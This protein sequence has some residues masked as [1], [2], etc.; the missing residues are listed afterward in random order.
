M[1]DDT[2][3]VTLMWANNEI[4]TINEVPQIGALC[5]DR[6]V[7]LPHRRDAVGRQD[8]H[9]CQHRQHRPAELSAVTRST[10]P[11]ASARSTSGAASPAS[12]SS[13]AGRR[14]PR[15]RHALAARSTSPAS[16]G[17]GKACEIL[18]QEMD[19]ERRASAGCAKKLERA[20][21]PS[22]ITSGQRR[23]RARLPHLDQHLLRLRRGR[24]AD[25]GHQG[26]R[27]ELGLGLHLRQPRAQLC[28]Q[29]LSASAMTGPL[30]APLQPRPL[31]HRRKRS[32]SRSPDHQRGQEAPRAQ[33][34]L[35]HAQ[36]G[37]D[38]TKIEWQAH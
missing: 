26:H 36:E 22:S 30:V 9:R 18:P 34:A 12:G 5:H 33:P 8:A 14:R 28:A 7:D 31:Q 2:I 27:D 6:G 35:R 10:A 16:S 38:I 37:I 24:V 3:L 13:R 1:R 19:S 23:R 4:G 25:D 32:T 29:G 15:A 17:M 20:R 11:R 21:P